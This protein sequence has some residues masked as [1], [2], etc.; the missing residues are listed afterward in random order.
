MLFLTLSRHVVFREGF[1]SEAAML[2][3]REGFFSEAAMLFLTLSRHV[4]FTYYFLS[5]SLRLLYLRKKKK[6]MRQPGFEPGKFR[7]R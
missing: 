3:F 2:F 7:R 5:V 1:F 6:E 4:V